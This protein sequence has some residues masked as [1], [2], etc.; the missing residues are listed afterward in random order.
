M[1]IKFNNRE[2]NL[3]Y[4][5]REKYMYEEVEQKTFDY[6]DMVFK[7]NQIELYYCTVISTITYLNNKNRN[8]PDWENIETNFTYE[9]LVDFV[10]EQTELGLAE[11]CEW[12]VNQQI[13]EAEIIKK[14]QENEEKNKKNKKEKKSD[15]KLEKNV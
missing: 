9:D 5:V 13:A 1:K 15:L 12:F 6:A 4:S 8:N 3:H 10:D 2:F 14:K 7:K 11:F